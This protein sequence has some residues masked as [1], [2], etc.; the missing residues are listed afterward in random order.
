[1]APPVGDVLDL[2]QAGSEIKRPLI[3]SFFNNDPKIL[4]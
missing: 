2:A 1:M 3:L 4:P